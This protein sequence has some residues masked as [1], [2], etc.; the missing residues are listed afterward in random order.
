M[1]QRET[2]EMIVY[3][4]MIIQSGHRMA[5]LTCRRTL[6]VDEEIWKTA[7]SYLC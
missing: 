7:S 1:P 5:R 3:L 4:K 6:Q 2:I